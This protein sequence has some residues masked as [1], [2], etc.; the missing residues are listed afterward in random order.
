MIMKTIYIQPQTK[1]LLVCPSL[2]RVA[3][4][5]DAILPRHPAKVIDK[6]T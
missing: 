4:G 6:Q 2:M 1:E 3:E 5:S